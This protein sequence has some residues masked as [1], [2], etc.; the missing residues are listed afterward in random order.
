MDDS[1]AI[2]CQLSAL[3][4]RLDQ[5]NCCQICQFSNKG[6][7]Y[8]PHNVLRP[9]DAPELTELSWLWTA[10]S[11]AVKYSVNHCSPQAMFC[12]PRTLHIVSPL[13]LQAL[14]PSLCYLTAT[15]TK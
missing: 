5:S 13:P 1:S 14:V 6:S 12:V 11:D 8:M 3:K 9:I 4:D 7:T 10:W 2:L 15:D